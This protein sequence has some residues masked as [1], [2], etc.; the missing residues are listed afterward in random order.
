MKDTT[1]TK[2]L[3]AKRTAQRLAEPYQAENSNKHVIVPA[4]AWDSLL[5]ACQAVL[6]EE[7]S[8]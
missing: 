6:L 1:L 7:I 8:Q 3:T 5:E 2:L 4:H